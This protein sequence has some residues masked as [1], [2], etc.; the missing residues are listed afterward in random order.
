[1]I[2]LSA[3]LFYYGGVVV[4]IISV[5][6][7]KVTN[8]RIAETE[9]VVYEDRVEGLAGNQYFPGASFRVKNFILLYEQITSVDVEKEIIVV[10]TYS[11][12][13]KVYANN[14]NDI[15]NVIFAQ[16]KKYYNQ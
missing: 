5:I 7:V 1:M 10:H 12:H 14:A 2:K 4:I 6:S 3:D 8:T 16:C 15:R 9:I 13:Y 11:T